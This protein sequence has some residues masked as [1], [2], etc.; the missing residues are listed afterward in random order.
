M[1]NNKALVEISVPASREKF[2][3]LIPLESKMS[4]VLKLVSS[5]LSEL[6][7]GR[8]RATES[9]VLCDAN[10]GMIYNVNM[11]VA[12]LGIKNGSHL[13]LI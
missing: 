13:M 2:D 6:T 10:S 8:Y 3:V 1:T 11:E 7:D 12:E 5:A 4:D 9:A